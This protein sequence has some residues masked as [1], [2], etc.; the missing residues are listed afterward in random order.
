[1]LTGVEQIADELAAAQDLVRAAVAALVPDDDRLRLPSPTQTSLARQG[2]FPQYAYE[3]AWTGREI[4]GHL[5]DSADI[6][7]DRIQL[8]Q[9][10]C[11]PVLA[12]FVTDDPVRLERYR[13][14]PLSDLHRDLDRAQQRLH[15]AVTRVSTDQL[16]LRGRHV[17]DGST[18]LADL[19]SFLPLHQADHATQLAQMVKAVS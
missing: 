12:D 7:A 2:H 14:Q 1:M 18:S 15:R 8:M 17:V 13:S 9:R 6:F 4:I 19:M 11:T 3:L 10:G 5:R 16:V